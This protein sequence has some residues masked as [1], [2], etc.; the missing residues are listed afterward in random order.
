MTPAS[1]VVDDEP[2]IRRALGINL[3]AR[4][5]ESLLRADGRS[6]LRLASQHHPDAV[7]VDLGLPDI[8]GVEVIEGS[9]AGQVPIIVLSVR[10]GEPTRSRRSTPAPTTT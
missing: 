10:E 8:D 4:G 2:Q 3:K 1:C 9:A 6:G 7:I 5:F